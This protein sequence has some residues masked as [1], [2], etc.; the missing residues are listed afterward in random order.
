MVMARAGR[1]AR[2]GT[3]TVQI[4]RVIRMDMLSRSGNAA[5]EESK[6]G[7]RLAVG[8]THKVHHAL[9]R[10]NDCRQHKP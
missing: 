3:R 6:I 7:G 5:K 9:A 2:A 10:P 1:A 8:I 4:V